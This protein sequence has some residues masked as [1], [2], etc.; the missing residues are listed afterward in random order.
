MQLTSLLE[1]VLPEDLATTH[2]HLGYRTIATQRSLYL[3]YALNIYHQPLRDQANIALISLLERVNPNTLLEPAT[4]GHTCRQVYALSFYE[5]LIKL[6]V[7]LKNPPVTKYTPEKYQDAQ[8]S[9][10]YS[11]ISLGVGERSFS[12]IP[13][14][15][16]PG[17]A[18]YSLEKSDNL[19][20]IPHYRHVSV[21]RQR[22]LSHIPQIKTPGP[23]SY[24]VGANYNKYDWTVQRQRANLYKDI[25]KSP[26]RMRK[27]Q[28][29][30]LSALL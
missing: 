14:K 24:N 22:E 12:Y 18:S 13:K 2:S 3:K 17:P 25:R 8:K 4:I 21:E 26:S 1:T 7:A 16:V 28:D 5:A 11:R 10:K 30:N 20:R 19:K 9:Q 27:N 15:D 23:G 29:Q 6:L